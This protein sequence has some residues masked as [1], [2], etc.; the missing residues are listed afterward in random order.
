MKIQKFNWQIWAGF[1]FSVIA[2]LS[3]PFVFVR[4][5]ITRDFPWANLLLFGIAAVLVF[6]GVRRAFGPERRRI[7]KIAASL[8][9]TLSVVVLGFFI[10]AAFVMSRWLPAA[11]GAP[12]IG[13][14]APDFTLADTNRK[15][16][17]LSELLSAPINGKAPKGVLLIF[18][19][20]Y[21]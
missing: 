5:P 16:G 1:V 14:K 3:Y 7:S 9:A 11:H 4:W 18:Y 10:F 12:Q 17:S 15:Q 19:R 8:L 6:I 20:G 21:W 13:Q 2:L